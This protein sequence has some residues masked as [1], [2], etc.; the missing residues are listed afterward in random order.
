M[1]ELS[2]GLHNDMLRRLDYVTTTGSCVL[3]GVIEKVN[4]GS[5]GRDNVGIFIK[6][7]LTTLPFLL[8]DY[9]GSGLG[10][11]GL[12]TSEECCMYHN[13]EWCMYHNHEFTLKVD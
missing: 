13:H 7:L 8:S 12:S 3:A 9:I 10:G 1:A 6:D 11:V 5:I 2:G 4:K